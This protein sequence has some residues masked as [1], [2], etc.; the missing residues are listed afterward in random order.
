MQGLVI[1]W[2]VSA[3]ALW[4]TSAI[5]SGIE[6]RTTGALFA[7]AAMIGILNAFVRPVIVLLTLPLT[8]VTLGLFILVINAAMLKIA[9]NIVP[10]FVVHGWLSAFAGWLLL[11][12]FTFLINLVIGESGIDVVHVRS[13]ERF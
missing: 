1:R 10:G 9:S 2:L 12:L 8:V 6:V 5:I 4:L 13:I 11:S 3:L 7:A